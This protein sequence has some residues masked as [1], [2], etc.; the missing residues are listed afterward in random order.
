MPK[1]LICI[2]SS[3]TVYTVTATF[4][5]GQWVNMVQCWTRQT[6]Y[7]TKLPTEISAPGHVSVRDYFVIT[8][9]SQWTWWHLKSPA[10]RLFTQ[11]LIQAQIKENIRWPVNSPHKGPVM[12]K[13]FPFDDVIMYMCPANERRRYIVA[14][15]LIGWAHT[16]NDPYKLTTN[17]STTKPAPSYL[18]LPLHLMKEGYS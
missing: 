15:S 7:S 8:V 6:F 9:T 2:I 17:T 12:W 5:R 16:Q 14:S 11:V 4:L 3:K 1:L 10:S 13:M 18:F